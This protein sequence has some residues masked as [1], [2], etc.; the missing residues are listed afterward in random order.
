M[1]AHVRQPL[2]K[3]LAEIADFFGVLGQ[4]FLPLSETT[5]TW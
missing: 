3:L 5:W 1:V 4:L 2:V